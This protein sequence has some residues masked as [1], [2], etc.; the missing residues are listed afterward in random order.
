MHVSG[1]MLV[2]ETEDRS[3]RKYCDTRHP[4]PDR[5][6]P[7]LRIK[8]PF[9]RAF[10]TSPDLYFLSLCLVG[11]GFTTFNGSKISRFILVSPPSA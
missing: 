7:R 11:T 9:P 5:L 8:L 4:A 6:R 10:V 3:G 2:N 1:A